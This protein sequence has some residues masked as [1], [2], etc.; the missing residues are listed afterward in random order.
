MEEAYEP[1]HE[2]IDGGLDLLLLHLRL[3][4]GRGTGLRR[5]ADD[6]RHQ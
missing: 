2:R 6:D 3:L 1:L 4:R 5:A